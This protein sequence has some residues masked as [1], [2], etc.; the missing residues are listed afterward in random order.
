MMGG[1]R[2]YSRTTLLNIPSSDPTM[3]NQIDWPSDKILQKLYDSDLTYEEI[4]N[5]IGGSRTSVSNK[6]HEK[7]I[8]DE[9]PRKHSSQKNKRH[10]PSDAVLQAWCDGGMS[11]RAMAELLDTNASQIKAHFEETEDLEWHPSESLSLGLQWPPSRHL[12]AWYNTWG[13]THEQI[14]D[15]LGCATTTVGQKFRDDSELESSTR[16]GGVFWPDDD[17]FSSFVEDAA[18]LT[19]EALQDWVEEKT[20]SRP[21]AHHVIQKCRRMDVDVEEVLE[22]DVSGLLPVYIGALE[23]T[24]EDEVDLPIED[25]RLAKAL[26]SGHP[27]VDQALRIALIYGTYDDKQWVLDQMVRSLVGGCYPHFQA[28]YLALHGEAWELGEQP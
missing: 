18:P 5:L 23:D 1:I 10:W 12:R 21:S 4:G 14:G 22:L 24:S 6:M 8:A 15:W 27:P 3:S 19:V 26:L 16:G 13:W 11:K 20:G 7:G 9:T 28:L 25:H 17:V 2:Q